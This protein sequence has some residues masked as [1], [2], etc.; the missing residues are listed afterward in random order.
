[1]VPLI[2]YAFL[3][4]TIVISFWSSL[5]EAT[6][7]T[8][9][10]FSLSA[11]IDDPAANASKALAIVSEKTKLVSV[12]TMVDTFSN[13]VLATSMGLVLSA[14]LG[15]IGWVYS[16][17]AG[18][19]VIMTLLYLLPKAIGIENALRMSLSLAPSTKLV[20]DALS[21]AAVPLTIM[22][23]KLSEKLVGKPGYTEIDLSDEFE[24]VVTMLEKAGHIEPDAGRL[25]RTAL[26]SSKT[27]A[28]D[29]LTPLDEISSVSSGAT[30]L[31]AL[32]AMG[33][34]SHPRM[35]VFDPQRK[36]YIGAVTFRTISKALSRSPLDSSI[37]DYMIQPAR[38]SKDDGLATVI[39]KM[40]DAG[41]TIAFVY[42]E[43]MIG[44]ITLSDILERLLGVKV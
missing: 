20:L 1:M 24:A 41:T 15:P 2:V 13:V 3:I 44:M 26:A 28:M 21:P 30:I 17:V 10:P 34:T 27:V 35:P 4:A 6:Y 8:L 25:L 38:V 33:E 11:T 12:T 22:A 16:A 42:E 37:L 40:Q 5:V 43:T 29:A 18:S 23:R 36:E 32:K 14:Y 7:L 31:E 19:F 9:R 39:E